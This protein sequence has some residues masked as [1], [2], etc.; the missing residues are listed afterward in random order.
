VGS[1]EGCRVKI[2]YPDPNWTRDPVTGKID[3]M[4]A[5]L[6]AFLEGCLR[7]KPDDVVSRSAPEGRR[8]YPGVCPVCHGDGLR[9]GCVECDDTGC[10]WVE[11]PADRIVRIAR[12]IGGAA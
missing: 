7:A 2:P 6:D 11:L 8:M 5:R 10:R 12:L 9:H 4:G 1:A 3:V